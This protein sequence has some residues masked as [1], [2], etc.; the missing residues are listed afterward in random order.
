MNWSNMLSLTVWKFTDDNVN[1][2]KIK[3]VLAL[4]KPWQNRIRFHLN[5]HWKSL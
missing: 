3:L 2:A 4:D 1:V 5:R